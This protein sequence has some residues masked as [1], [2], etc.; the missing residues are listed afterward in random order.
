MSDPFQVAAAVGGC[1]DIGLKFYNT[2]A[3]LVKEAKLA[4]TTATALAN[5]VQTLN[6]TLEQVKEICDLETASG[7][8]NVQNIG[9]AISESIKSC[10][11]TLETYAAEVDQLRAKQS[12]PSLWQRTIQALKIQQADS[13]MSRFESGIQTHLLAIQLNIST[14]QM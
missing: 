1:I 2:I 12:G 11:S 13:T 7:D 6:S 5:K 9:R 4:H 8:E 14:L 10:K 3:V